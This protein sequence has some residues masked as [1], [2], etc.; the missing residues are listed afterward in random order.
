MK[1]QQC[2]IVIMQGY[3]YNRY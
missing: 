1:L 2:N 3:N